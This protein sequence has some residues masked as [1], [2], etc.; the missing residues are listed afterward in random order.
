MFASAA[1]NATAPN[2]SGFA[3]ALGFVV[4]GVFLTECVFSYPGIGYVLLDPR[5]WRPG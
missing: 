5:I 1:R 3:L 4:G 2:V